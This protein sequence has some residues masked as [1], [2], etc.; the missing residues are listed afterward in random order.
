MTTQPRFRVHATGPARRDIA[1]VA[2]WSKQEYGI[3]ASS[4]YESLIWQAIGDIQSDPERLG[5]RTRA[6]FSDPV[7]VY[8]LEF[9]RRR[10]PPDQQVRR[11][12]HYFVYR[13]KDDVVE[14]LRLIHDAQDLQRQLPDEDA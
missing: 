13:I 7:S 6:E 9:S 11:P 14:I 5:V 3:R 12:R 1:A 10:L 2:R 4:R 8:H